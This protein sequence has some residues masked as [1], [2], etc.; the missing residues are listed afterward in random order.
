MARTECAAAVAKRP[1]PALRRLATSHLSRTRR[2]NVVRTSPHFGRRRRSRLQSRSQSQLSLGSII[3]L[4]TQ[5]KR[6]SRDEVSYFKRSRIYDI[7]CTLMMPTR[8]AVGLEPLNALDAAH[9]SPRSVFHSELVPP[10]T[11]S[12]R[13]IK[14]N[15]E[16]AEI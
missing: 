9:R 7:P 10:L 3:I 16:L 6:H 5:T 13:I 2:T 11:R 15:K 4:L 8:L 1:L 14:R 12:S